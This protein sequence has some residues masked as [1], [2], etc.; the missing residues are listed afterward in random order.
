MENGKHARHNSE[1][2]PPSQLGM[3]GISGIFI[4]GM[5]ARPP[6]PGSAGA[7]P[8]FGASCV[9]VWCQHTVQMFAPRKQ[10]P[11]RARA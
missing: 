3:G 8:S 4:S 5:P 11:L 2:H 9:W 10:V 6:L 7:S 1:T